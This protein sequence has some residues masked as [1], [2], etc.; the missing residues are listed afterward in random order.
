MPMCM[1]VCSFKRELFP[2]NEGNGAGLESQPL[3]SVLLVQGSSGLQQEGEQ[4][5]YLSARSYGG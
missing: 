2:L 4:T 5:L 3:I 1:G